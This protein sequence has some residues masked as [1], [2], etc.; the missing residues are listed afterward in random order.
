MY[1]TIIHTWWNYYYRFYFNY[2]EDA[3]I[4]YCNKNGT[5][6]IYDSNNNKECTINIDILTDLYNQT[7]NKDVELYLKAI[8]G[9]DSGALK[10]IST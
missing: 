9:H 2:L 4:Y 10:S 5:V 7:K 1:Y 6:K 3:L 8:E